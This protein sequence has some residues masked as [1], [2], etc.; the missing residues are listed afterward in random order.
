L[1]L[2]HHVRS[3]SKPTYA[4]NCQNAQAPESGVSI[5]RRSIGHAAVKF[6]AD[7][8]G[9]YRLAGWP[10]VLTMAV[11]ADRRKRAQDRDLML[12]FGCAV[13]C[14]GPGLILFCRAGMSERSDRNLPRP[15]DAGARVFLNIG[16]RTLPS[17]RRHLV[18]PG[19]PAVTSVLVR[20]FQI[21]RSSRGGDRV[22]FGDHV[23]N[24]GPFAI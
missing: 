6:D 5:A 3:W 16:Q 12:A 15:G 9:R 18:R 23:R 17:G 13:S 2:P 4:E 21:R 20:A 11:A 14:V 22:C 7:H 10:G 8:L 19:L 24:A 1:S